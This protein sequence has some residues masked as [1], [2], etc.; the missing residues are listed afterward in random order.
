MKLINYIKK[1]KNIKKLIILLLI[2]YFIYIGNKIIFQHE[3]DIWKS[4]IYVTVFD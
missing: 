1:V 2:I 4:L 3:C